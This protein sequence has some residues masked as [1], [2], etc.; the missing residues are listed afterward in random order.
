M[1]IKV[2][3]TVAYGSDVDLVREIM[4]QCAVDV[5][6]VCT[7][8]PTAVR[9][10]AMADSGLNFE[11][12]TWATHPV[13]QGRVI[14]ESI[15]ASTRRSRRRAWRSRSRNGTSTSRAGRHRR[16]S[17]TTVPS[18]TTPVQCVVYSNGSPS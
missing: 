14:D 18:M 1:R 12:R 7:E 15:R 11:I 2:P 10:M 3:V 13:F 4:E 8:Q 9:F 16:R 6:H 5:P 17:E